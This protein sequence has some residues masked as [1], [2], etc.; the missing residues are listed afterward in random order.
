MQLADGFALAAVAC[1]LA[2]AVY[3]LKRFE[4]P[5]ALSIALLAAAV[6]YGFA[7]PGFGW[8]WHG[9][10]VV[11]VFAFGLLSFSRGWLGG[12]DVKLLTGVAAW[13]SIGQVL[14]L[15]SCIAISGGMLAIMLLAA[16][17]G[18]KLIAAEAA[19]PRVFRAGEPLPYAVAIAAGS[20]WWAVWTYPPL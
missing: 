19:P 18:L 3:D 20:L 7:T 1:L 11:A 4:I 14:L 13:A 12:G 15:M 17:G 8:G 16:R 9:L 5:D 10:S 2:G 6:G